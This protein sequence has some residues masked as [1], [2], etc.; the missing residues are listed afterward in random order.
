MT[1]QGLIITS[2]ILMLF[3]SAPAQ[4]ELVIIGNDKTV[5]SKLNTRIIS[6]IYTGKVIEIE[7]VSVIPVNSTQ[8]TSLRNRFLE[9]Y[10]SQNE[11]EYSAYWTVRRFIGKGTPPKEFASVTDI[12]TYVA[13]TPGAIGYIDTDLISV[14]SSVKIINQ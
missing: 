4:S 7:G 2:L 13:E 11:N 6:R 1:N 5:F 3:V 8:T 12:I 14:P 9:K 10:L